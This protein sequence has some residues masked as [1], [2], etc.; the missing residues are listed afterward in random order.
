MT[1]RKQARTRET[2]AVGALMVAAAGL[3]PTSAEAGL[4]SPSITISKR[5]DFEVTLSDDQDYTVAGHL[6]MK[7]GGHCGLFLDRTLQVLLHGGTYDHEYWDAPQINGER[8]SYADYMT[9]RCY[10]VL[11]LDMLG[12]GASSAPA[13]DL[14]DLAESASALEQVLT[15]VRAADLLWEP[16]FDKIVLVGHSMGTITSVY[17][18]GNYGPIADALVATGWAHAPRIIPIDP[19]AFEGP[20]QQPYV[21][22]PPPV[23]ELLFYYPPTSDPDVIAY[24]NANLVSGLPRG[25][26]L[27][28]LDMMTALAIGD[29]EGI[30]GLSLVDQVEVPVL[31]QLGQYDII[32][33]AD[34]A[35]QEAAFYS[36]SPDVTVQVLPDIG[37]DVN[38]HLN[39]ETGW[40]QIDA[41]IAA[42]VGK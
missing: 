25:L 1:D 31:S 39:R 12:A 16:V 26:M 13:G 14:A 11:A 9:D 6:S 41:W 33:T 29:P 3:L 20:L 4:L 23:R 38:L 22:M 2:R 7:V 17:A 34:V 18:L 10:A 28:V 42:K 32:A 24:D 5:V 19:A 30:N 21:V 15:R 35:A 37:H 8:Y 36:S 40:A 27:D